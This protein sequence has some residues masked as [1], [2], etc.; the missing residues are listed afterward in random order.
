MRLAILVETW[1]LR[2]GEVTPALA[3][4][5]VKRPVGARRS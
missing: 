3:R 1:P 2:P 4:F 5:S